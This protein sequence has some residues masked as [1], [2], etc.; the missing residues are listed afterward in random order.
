MVKMNQSD[1]ATPLRYKNMQEEI[2]KNQTTDQLINKASQKM[3]FY[4]KD[5]QDSN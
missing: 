1:N 4:S 5:F 2:D 3:R